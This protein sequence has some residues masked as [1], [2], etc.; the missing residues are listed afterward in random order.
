[1]RPELTWPADI[2]LEGSDQ[3]RGWFQSS[4]LV[5]LGTRGRPPFREVVTHG[6]IVAEDGRKMS[7]SLG[8]SIE[9]QDI[10][11]QS[12]ADILRLWVSMSDYTQEIRVSKE[13]L[14][15][16]RRGVPEDP[17][18]AAVS[19]RRTSTTSIPAT[20]PRAA[21]RSSRRS[22]AT[23]SRATRTSATQVLRGYE[24]YDYGTIFQALNAFAT[25]DLS[26]FYDDVSKDR[27]Y[28]F[29]A[30]LARA[31]L[32]ADG[33]VPDGRRPDAA[34]RADPVVHRR[35]AVAVTCPGAREES[36]HMALFPDARRSSTRSPIAALRRALDTADR[37]PRAG[38][39][40]DRAA[41]Q[42]QADRQLA[43]GEG[44]AVGDAGGAGAA[45]AVRARSCRCC[46]SCPRS[47]CGRRRRR[48]GARRGDAARH[49]RARRRRE[50]RAL[51]ALRADGLDRSG[52][53]RAVR[54]LPG[55]AWPR[56]S[57]DNA[58]EASDRRQREAAAP[59]PPRAA[60]VLAAAG[61]R[62]ASIS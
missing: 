31:A 62:R 61:H 53:G 47:S 41:A 33:D 20:R 52:V 5:G 9:P 10:I 19:A 17:Q 16:R 8:N 25:V 48:R 60:R 34:A 23:S 22:I 4:L 1:M 27:L 37:A 32:G 29:A 28:T 59:A 15:A 26:A 50:V 11:K 49:H 54:P 2:Y 21:S 57:M 38:A 39:G 14:R 43:A 36:V 30:A 58:I 24:E 56:R 13:I 51:L 7:K 44:R 45:R 12:G 42:E 55:R 40:G 46:S 3:H 6:F 18:H 35:R